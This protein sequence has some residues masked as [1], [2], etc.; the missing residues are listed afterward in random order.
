MPETA[1][2]TEKEGLSLIYK[3]ALS[4]SDKIK[5]NWRPGKT[6]SSRHRRLAW[7]C[8]PMCLWHADTG[9]TKV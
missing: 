6:S 3:K 1:C 5:V 8:G 2:K 7:T 4:E 9:W